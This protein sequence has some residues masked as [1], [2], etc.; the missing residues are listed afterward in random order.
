VCKPRQPSRQLVT[1]QWLRF[2]G[3]T[4]AE[5]AGATE[6]V[7]L[8]PV[9][10]TWPDRYPRSVRLHDDDQPTGN[11]LGQEG[12]S[13]LSI[14]ETTDMAT[15]MSCA[16]IYRGN[17]RRVDSTRSSNALTAGVASMGVS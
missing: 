9:F 11:G 10:P 14:E 8:A 17:V 2:L 7:V 6:H 12:I 16:R 5:A 3:R 15:G 1:L 13:S 4:L